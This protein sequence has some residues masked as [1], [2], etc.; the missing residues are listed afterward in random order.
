[1]VCA[2]PLEIA[3]M[4]LY[5]KALKVSPISMTVPFLA[6]TPVFLIAT[7]YVFLGERVSIY[8]AIGII[9]MAVGSYALNIHKVRHDLLEPVKA[10]FKEKGSVM[11]IMVA[12][13]FSI[14][15][16]LGKMAIEHSSPVF[17]GSFY[18]ILVLVCFTPIAYKKSGGNLTIK[19]EDLKPLAFI[20]LTFSLMI[21]FHMMAISMTKAAYMIAIKRT[22][23]LFSICYGY[24]LF[25]EEKIAEKAIGG[26]I[27]LAGFI[28]IVMSK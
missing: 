4:I 8:G 20:G 24:F 28:F 22:S 12:F 7:S 9:L 21:I 15:S 14:T 5:V 25:K 17:F 10:V 11:M 23:L 27:M 6:L 2:L 13:I 26:V 3:A 16:S 18:F 1:V 19:K